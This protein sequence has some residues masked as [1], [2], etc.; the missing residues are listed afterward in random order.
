MDDGTTD[1]LELETQLNEATRRYAYVT[2]QDVDFCDNHTNS[3]IAELELQSDPDSI[4]A[5]NDLKALKRAKK[6]TQT[7]SKIQRILK[8][9]NSGTLSR[10][11]VPQDMAHKFAKA[12]FDN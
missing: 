8:P 3:L 1:Q 5:L 9:S 12:D 10:V 11:D 2:K 6:L 7:F 4:K